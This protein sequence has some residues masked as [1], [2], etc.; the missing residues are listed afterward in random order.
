[1]DGPGLLDVAQGGCTRLEPEVEDGN[2]EYKYMLKQPSEL[3]VQQ[4]T[5]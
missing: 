1:M 3:R 4:L 2:V 5:R